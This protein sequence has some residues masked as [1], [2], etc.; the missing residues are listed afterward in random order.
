MRDRCEKQARYVLLLV[1][2]LLSLAGC[3][4]EKGDVTGKP[5]DGRA[6]DSSPLILTVSILP[7]TYF[8][9]RIAGDRARITVLTGPGQN[10]HDY[11]PTPRQMA[12]LAQS[13]VWVLSG[14]EFE[15]GLEPKI[16]ALF[17]GL[18]I[19]DGTEGVRFRSP[20]AHDDEDEHEA[21]EADRHTWLGEEPAKIMARKI[22]DALVEADGDNG[23]FYANNYQALVADIEEEFDALRSELAPLRGSRVFVYHPAFG[24]FLDEFGITQEAVETGGKEPTPRQLAALIAQAREERPL[25]I[26]VQAQFPVRA[27]ETVAVAAGAELIT[28]DPLSPDWLA[29]I[30]LM[31]EALRKA[32]GPAVAQEA[33]R[34]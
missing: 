23:E 16:A 34:E 5:A 32:A 11:E 33:A 24:Y 8:A 7:Q 13:R 1:M 20:E 27:A 22:L 9:G 31:G 2:G 30:R 29:N 14:S 17:P 15:I 3:F 28:L 25:A 4:G 18:R 6:A 19:V 12:E 21:G 26:F 10:P